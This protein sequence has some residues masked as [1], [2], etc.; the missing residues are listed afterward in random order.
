M[1]YSY[2]TSGHE[3]KINN[4]SNCNVYDFFNPNLTSYGIYVYSNSSNWTISGNNFYETTD[5]VPTSSASYYSIKVYSTTGNNFLI[6]GNFIGGQS[7]SCGG[8]P[9]RINVAQ[10]SRFY[11]IHLDVGTTLPTSVQNNTIQNFDITNTNNIPFIGIDVNSGSANLGTVT[12]NT[13]G[14]PTGNS[15]IVLTNVINSAISYGIY[16]ISTG[17]VAVSNN[18][19]G[20][21]TTIGGSTSPHSLVAIHKASAGAGNITIGNN[22]VG[23]QTTSNSLQASSILESSTAQN[24]YG[25]YSTGTGTTLIS[26]NTVANLSNAYNYQYAT[27]GQTIG[28]YTTGGAN[29]IQNNAVMNI[30]AANG[31]NDPNANAAV[32]GISQ[33]STNTGQTISGNTIYNLSSPYTGTRPVSVIGIFSSGGTTGPNSIFGNF[34]YGFSISATASASTPAILCG[35]KL[36]AGTTNTYNNIVNLGAGVTNVCNISGI[37][38]NGS[39]GNDN[40]IFFNAIYI[41][42]STSGQTASTYALFSNANTNVRDFRNNIF[43]NARSGGSTG[44]HYAIRLNGTAN[45][46]FDYNDYYVNGTNGVLGVLVSIDKTTLTIWKS[47]TSQDSHSLAID[48]GYSSAGGTLP[49][50]YYTSGTLPGMAGTGITIDFASNARSLTPKMGALESNSYVWQGVTGTDFATAS[51]WSGGVVPPNGSDISFAA[52]PANNCILDQNRTLGVITNAQSSR[53]LVLNGK[54]LTINGNL[55]FT[56][57]AQIDATTTS[58]VVVFAGTSAQNIPSGSFVSNTLDGLTINNSSGLTQNGDLTVNQNLN[59]TN[60]SFSVGANTLTLNGG[61]TVTSGT[62]N[63]GSSTNMIIGGNGASTVLPTV[64]LNNLTL[65]RANGISLGGNINISGTIELTSGTL[66]IRAYTL[67]LS[68]TS[69]TRTTGCIDASDASATLVFAN[70]TAIALPSSIFCAAV[71]N[72]IINGSGGITA[73]SD[74]T[75]N[76]M[77]I[78]QN[79]NPNATKGLLDMWDGSAN[80]TLTMGVNATTTGTGDVTGVVTRNYF[81]SNTTYTF[82]NQFTTITFCHLAEICHRS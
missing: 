2:G 42:G 80:K 52:S 21:M 22:L 57:N 17:T 33:R 66:A 70:S 64:S 9:W 63:G 30:S 3:N 58:S 72:L 7:A 31:S 28:I 74:F 79:V 32:I 53:K 37:Y 29:T 34:V 15:S 61:I 24:V 50:N 1:I 35:I 78:L 75:V 40:S 36:L 6:S 45:S 8:S 48:P 54:Q 82:G 47:A 55:N 43:Y 5:F 12:G 69:L 38:E 65:N 77:L 11:G 14:A 71:N 60:G 68:G 44:K 10:A 39:A 18:T 51:N 81:I 23:S 59:L 27:N 67:T 56:N 16:V 41:G 62:L 25:I 19:V 13:I 4:V 46:T 49:A 20:S 76:G 26:N 73:N